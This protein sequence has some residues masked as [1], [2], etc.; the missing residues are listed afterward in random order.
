VGSRHVVLI[1]RYFNAKL[2]TVGRHYAGPSSERVESSGASST[3]LGL[4]ALGFLTLGAP[5]VPG[6]P[7]HPTCELGEQEYQLYT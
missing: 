3:A 2:S 5:R 4:P 1:S 7:K 6:L